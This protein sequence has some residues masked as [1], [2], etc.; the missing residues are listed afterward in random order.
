MS[1]CFQV[2]ER[3]LREDTMATFP[4]EIHEWLLEHDWEFGYKD[5]ELI[6]FVNGKKA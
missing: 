6:E 5:H 2:C 3:E 1:Q 4:N